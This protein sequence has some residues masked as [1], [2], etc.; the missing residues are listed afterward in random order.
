MPHRRL[1]LVLAVLVFAFDQASKHAVIDAAG[2]GGG[3]PLALGPWLDFVLVWNPGISYSLFSAQ[4]VAG[5]LALLGVT[6][7]VAAG[8]MVWLWRWPHSRAGA[9]A[10]GC[11]I[12]GALGNAFDRAVYGK[13]ADFIHIH[14]GA[15]APFGVF[16]FADMAIFAGV[17]LLL[18]DGL[19][20]ASAPAPGGGGEA[21]SKLP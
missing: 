15:F 14:F 13:V 2:L 20:P 12:G 4:S 17:A 16:N 10:L 5:W 21:A 18:Y 11:L 3:A 6:I 19:F 1:G 7:A 8:L 9:A